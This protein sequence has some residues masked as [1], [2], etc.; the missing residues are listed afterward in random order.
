METKPYPPISILTPTYNRS[1]F[2]N[3]AIFNVMQFDYP[4]EKIT[5]E[6]LDDGDKPFLT[7]D[8]LNDVIRLIAPRRIKYT[9]NNSRHLSIGEKRNRLV[10]GAVNN[11]I[12][13]MDDDDIYLATYLKYNIDLMR[14]HKA[15]LSC[16]P[17][18]AFVFPEDDF[19]MSFIQCRAKRQGHEATMVTTKKYIR[20]MDGF[21]KNSK[22]EG[23]KL[24][25]F[26]ESRVVKS[27]VKYCMI[28]VG[29]KYNTIDKSSFKDSKIDAVLPPIY[30]KILSDILDLDYEIV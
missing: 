27:E 3:L 9:Y 7:K 21:A 13:F 5:W 11:Y 6:I 10:K 8:E 1:N 17:Q 15:G 22:G 12:A 2:K 30:K 23:A 25:D 4:K 28:C 26:S 18:M 14:E 29:H 16:S 24:V 20:S 19:S